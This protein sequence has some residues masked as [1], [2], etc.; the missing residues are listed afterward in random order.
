MKNIFS[1][2]ILL[3][4]T[5]YI[6]F[7]DFN[8]YFDM[9][10][11]TPYFMDM[12]VASDNKIYI[13]GLDGAIHISEDKGKTWSIR[14]ANCEDMLISISGI[15]ENAI[16]ISSSGTI[17]YTKDGGLNWES[18]TS[19]ISHSL[20][21][22]VLCD[23][24]TGVAVGD[25]GIIIKTS[26]GGMNWY[27]I[28]TGITSDILSALVTETKAIIIATVDGDI[29][30]SSDNGDNWIKLNIPVQFGNRMKFSYS[31]DKVIYLLT[32][33]VLLKSSDDGDTW[34]YFTN[35]YSKSEFCYYTRNGNGFIGASQLKTKILKMCNDYQIIDTVNLS[36]DFEEVLPTA[37]KRIE[38][39][40]DNHGI[41]VGVY[42]TI[43]VTEDGGINW[44]E[45]SFFYTYPPEGK[46]SSIYF[47]NDSI[48]YIGAY[49]ESL[50]K[51]SDKGLSWHYV[52][53]DS[54]RGKF[55]SISSLNFFDENTGMMK[56][57]EWHGTL[58]ITYDGAKS[59][60]R[61]TVSNQMNGAM[62]QFDYLEDSSFFFIGWRWF[63]NTDHT[64]YGIREFNG[65]WHN[66]SVFDSCKLTSRYYHKD[67][68]FLC[69]YYIDSCKLPD[70]PY[71]YYRGMMVVLNDSCQ[72]WKKILFDNTEIINAVEFVDDNIGYAYAN[73][74]IYGKADKTIFYRTTDGGE[75]W[76]YLSNDTNIIQKVATLKNYNNRFNIGYGREMKYLFSSDYGSNW[77][78]INLP[79]S[80]SVQDFFATENCFYVTGMKGTFSYI[81]RLKLK[82]EYISVSEETQSLPAPLAYISIPYPNP[83]NDYTNFDIIWDKRYDIE[84]I[85]FS[86]SDVYGRII[87]NPV[88]ESITQSV[89]KATIKWKTD[90]IPKGLYI[91]QLEVEGYKRTQKVIVY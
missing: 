65:T 43:F 25:S 76:H 9:E 16:T 24:Q 64:Y 60:K 50:F 20:N 23:I 77:S 58:L 22:I 55:S 35:P 12:S 2:F 28:Q 75:S 17:R 47:I 53:K 48:G 83:A 89:N 54:L 21:C 36:V 27:E 37:L 52:K 87:E 63:Y 32:E 59:V 46:I 82:D 19:Y 31:L 4:S 34:D 42:N 41:A 15:G 70:E 5:I 68:I 86:V 73:D 71:I 78:E 3:L 29:Y 44:E 62:F 84:E 85:N 81:Y 57:N 13:C 40:D 33:N 74:Y 7:S 67:K 18:P 14:N 30:K 8:D 1:I 49:R 39:F 61:D 79:T 6:C 45:I 72:K 10:L 11:I 26:D 66:K 80:F 51:T 38:F 56:S 69:G 91:F 90:Y 88:I